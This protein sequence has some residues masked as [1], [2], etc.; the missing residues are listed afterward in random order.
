MPVYGSE[1]WCTTMRKLPVSS[2]T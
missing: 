2:L 1:E